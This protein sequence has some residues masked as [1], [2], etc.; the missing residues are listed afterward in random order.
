MR[1]GAILEDSTD[2]VVTRTLV[3]NVMATV[4]REHTRNTSAR[5]RFESSVKPEASIEREMLLMA[6]AI[7]DEIVTTEDYIDFIT[8]YLYSHYA[9][10]KQHR[11]HDFQSKL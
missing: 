10:N 9:F 6:A 11:S 3:R 2:T 4:L 5:P 8:T 1:H 7:F